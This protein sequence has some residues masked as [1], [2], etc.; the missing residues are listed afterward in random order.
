MSRLVLLSIAYAVFML[1]MHTLDIYKY[2]KTNAEVWKFEIY[3]PLWASLSKVNIILGFL[4]FILKVALIVV[5][6]VSRLYLITV[7]LVAVFYFYSLTAN[8]IKKRHA[9]SRD[10]HTKVAL[11]WSDFAIFIVLDSLYLASAVLK[12]IGFFDVT[13]TFGYFP[14]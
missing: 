12:A 6:V 14:W 10:I 13:I 4:I 7:A 2:G 1:C 8:K 3:H 5:F 11:R 9:L